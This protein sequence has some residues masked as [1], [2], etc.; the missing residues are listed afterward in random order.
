MAKGCEFLEEDE[1]MDGTDYECIN[2]KYAGK[3][4]CDNCP[5]GG[6][7]I[8]VGSLVRLTYAETFFTVTAIERGDGSRIYGKQPH[9][10]YCEPIART[11]H[12]KDYRL[13]SQSDYGAAMI[14]VSK[15]MDSSND[16]DRLNK[17]AAFCSE[18]ERINVSI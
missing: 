3:M 18:W 1:S 4:T 7:A 2:P 13:V 17:L 15:L 12:A 14:E 8:K 11:K 9:N 5:L 10:D 6:M 16:N